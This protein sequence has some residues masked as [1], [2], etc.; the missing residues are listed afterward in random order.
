MSVQL[1]PLG[2]RVLIRPDPAPTVT[3]SGL[4]LAEVRQ[5]EQTGTVLAVGRTVHP[6][7]GDVEAV[8]H[9]LQYYIEQGVPG[10]GAMVEAMGLLRELVTVEPSVQPGDYVVFSWA[11]GQS[12]RID[13]TDGVCLVLRER[14]LLCV[15]GQ[16]V[17]VETGDVNREVRV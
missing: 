5:P 10:S 9:S 11:A 4:H 7:A 3:A 14:D 16:G 12:L 13:D 15:V 6:R 2:D 8:I 1:R 17:Q